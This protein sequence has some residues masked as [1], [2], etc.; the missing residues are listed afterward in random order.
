MLRTIEVV[1]DGKTFVPSVPV[2]LPAGTRVTVQ[3]P[4]GGAAPRMSV[5]APPP[6]MT[7]AE[8]EEWDQ[9]VAKLQ[10]TE[11]PWPTV[12]EAVAAQRTTSWRPPE[13]GSCS[14]R[15]SC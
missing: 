5:G 6:P 9:F 10:A 8:R 12:D 11:L 15:T 4:D 13:G 3:V 2:D 14:T 1:F 7:D